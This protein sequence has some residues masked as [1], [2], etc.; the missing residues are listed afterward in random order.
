MTTPSLIYGMGHAVYSLSDP[1]ANIFKAFVESLS[2]EKG[3][4]D[5]FRLYSMVERLAPQV[6]AEER[7][8]Y[9]GVSANV[10]F[11]PALFTV[12]WI[13]PPSC[14]PPFSPSPGFPA[15][16]PTG[17]RS[18]P[19]PERSSV[20]LINVFKRCGNTPPCLNGKNS[21]SYQPVLYPRGPA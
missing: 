6:I 9:K 10:D 8:I 16:A 1:R 5:E 11:Y 4:E 17:S 7:K 14:L 2:K 18:W 12:C 15:G 19:M 13:F 3:R 21:C 20:P